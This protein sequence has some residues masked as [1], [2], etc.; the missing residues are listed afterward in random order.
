MS[1]T[2][3]DFL[4]RFATTALTVTG[5]NGAMA[6]ELGI[7]I[8][9]FGAVYGPPPYNEEDIKRF[10][11]SPA[12]ARVHFDDDKFTLNAQAQEL[13]DEQIRWLTR[14]QHYGVLLEGYT[15]DHCTREFCLSLSERLAL[16]VKDYMVSH[17][18]APQ[19]IM[20]IGYGKE[21]PAAIGT[22]KAARAQNRR[23]DTILQKR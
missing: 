12:T 8:A 6:G 11:S 16:S 14:Y 1:N 22:D 18:I 21:R 3:R 10:F 15:D 4:L 17:G 23:V 9:Q 7:Q 5:A 2:R 20:T 19:R 13:L